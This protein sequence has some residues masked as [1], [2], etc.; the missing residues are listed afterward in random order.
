MLIPRALKSI[1]SVLAVLCA[2]PAS[3]A[4]QQN[5]AA[6]QSTAQPVI[7]PVDGS[8]PEDGSRLTGVRLTSEN[9]KAFLFFLC[10]S[11]NTNPRIIFGHGQDIH[12][13][14]KPIGFDIAIDGTESQRHYFTVLKNS[15]SAVFFVRT[16]EMYHDRFGESPPVFNEQ[17]RS[18]NRQYIAWTDN[19]YNR[20]TADLFFGKLALLRFTDG[21]NKPHAYVFHLQRLA[22]NIGRLE[23]CYEAPWVY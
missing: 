10:D 15:R 13:P 8:D 5:E 4:A 7:V 20:V 2:L 16:A 11:D 19:I 1:L 23:S 9:G 12:K 6:S 17:T 21:A 18:V 22:E 14:T 3:V